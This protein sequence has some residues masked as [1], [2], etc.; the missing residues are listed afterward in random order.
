MVD[1]RP[2]T[3]SRIVIDRLL[4]EAGWDIEDK[5][6]VSTEEAAADGRADYLL[7]DSQGRPLAVIE[8]KRFSIEPTLAQQQAK[9]Y[10][11]SISAPF[12]FLS[13]GEIHYFWDYK[14]DASRPIDSFYSREDLQRRDKL[15]KISKPLNAVSM[16]S[17]FT[18]FNKDLEVRPYQIEAIETV[19]KAMEDGKKR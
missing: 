8:A 5:T 18:H 7:K 9:A 12:V 17:K 6:Q 19:D 3:D 10:A 14:Y 1:K 4:R 15:H 11:E 13:N 2:E 16:P